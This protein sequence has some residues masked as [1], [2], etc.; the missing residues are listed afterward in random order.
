MKIEDFSLS[1]GSQVSTM[2]FS[3]KRQEIRF[4]EHQRE[5]EISLK[6]VRVE[7][8][9]IRLE[10]EGDPRTF[11]IKKLV[12][13][14]TG[15]EIKTVT[16]KEL[17][18][19]NFQPFQEPQLGVELTR[20]EA[21][22]KANYLEFYA[23]GYIKTA[24]GR[25]IRFNVYVKL[26][27]LSLDVNKDTIR[28][29]SVALIDP[30]MIDLGGSSELLSP[31]YFEFDLDGDGRSDRVPLLAKG[32][33][34]IFFDGNNND[35]PDP[36]EIIGTQTGSAFSEL[37]DF[38]EDGNGWIDSGD[39]SFKYMRVWLPGQRVMSM[40]DAGVS[41]LYTGSASDFFELKDTSGK[42]RAIVKNIGIYL[43]NDASV[44][45]LFKVDLAV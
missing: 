34:F 19:R 5:K 26:L 44:R 25:E 6:P 30:L 10:D 17:T 32:K 15:K 11:L 31:G 24:E 12:E 27:N 42:L 45:T 1:M 16:Y 22:V 20:E 8:P 21:S 35:L 2:E 33:G 36:K 4:I 28:S 40:K 43:K 14:L 39:T 29:G 38:D 9:N 23:Y 3:L 41:A 7:N 13:I 37:K 18:E